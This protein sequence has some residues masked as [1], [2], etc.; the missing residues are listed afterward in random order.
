MQGRAEREGERGS[1]RLAI[2]AT[3]TSLIEEAREKRPFSFR[4]NHTSPHR[5]QPSWSKS[6]ILGPRGEPRLASP[7]HAIQ[8]HFSNQSNSL[9][10]ARNHTATRTARLPGT[11]QPNQYAQD[12]VSMSSSKAKT[13]KENQKG[14]THSPDS[15]KQVC[16]CMH[17]YMSYRLCVHVHLRV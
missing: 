7:G 14:E 4:T 9:P 6:M 17:A 2:S 1:M 13:E 12:G 16:V 8:M 11:S 3:E 15:G 10:L 5:G